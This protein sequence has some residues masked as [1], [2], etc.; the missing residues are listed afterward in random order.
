MDVPQPIRLGRGEENSAAGIQPQCY[1]I[2]QYRL[3]GTFKLEGG[4]AVK[5]VTSL[6]VYDRWG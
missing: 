4:R 5:S 2:W 1:P 6:E 3:Q